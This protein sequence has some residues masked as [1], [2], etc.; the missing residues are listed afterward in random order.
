MTKTFLTAEEL[1]QQFPNIIKSAQMALRM[2][3]KNQ[4]PSI[5]FGR[6]RFFCLESVIQHF[7]ELEQ[8]T[9]MKP[10]IKSEHNIPN[11]TKTLGQL[12]AIK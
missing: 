3:K 8:S 9:E 7:S 1:H 11:D 4:I 2:G 10:D 6:R 12:R 5:L